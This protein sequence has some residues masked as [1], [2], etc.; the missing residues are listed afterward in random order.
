MAL[1]SWQAGGRAGRPRVSGFWERNRSTLLRWRNLSPLCVDYAASSFFLVGVVLGV[2]LRGFLGVRE[3]R[4]R[5]IH[6][7]SEQL[8]ME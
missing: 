8:Q 5:F 2:G 3:A 7:C 1:A 4:S 6:A